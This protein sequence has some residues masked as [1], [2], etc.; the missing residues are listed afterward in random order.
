MKLLGNSMWTLSLSCNASELILER[1]SPVDTQLT[2]LNN[3]W[4]VSS[5][6]PHHHLVLSNFLILVS[7][8][9]KNTHNCFTLDLI[10]GEVEN[11]FMKIL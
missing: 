3:I 2:P 10:T 6:H 7:L 9:G 5:V 4:G 1:A 11:L 8:L